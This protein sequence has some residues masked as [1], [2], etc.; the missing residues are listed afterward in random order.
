M[1]FEYAGETAALLTSMVWA[2]SSQFHA[3][4]TKLLG[5]SGVTL[6]RVPYNILLLGVVFLFLR[7]EN[8]FSLE[9][10]LYIAAAAF[11]GIAF[12]DTS[13][14]KAV[15]LIGPRLACLVQSMSSCFTAI[16]GYFILGESIGV[17]G[18]LGI[19][20]AIFGVFFVL[21]DGGNLT[22]TPTGQSSKKELAHGAALG[23]F[24]ALM[25]AGS[26]I[27][28]K[29]AL[30]L[31]VSP[32]GA[33][34]LRLIF[35]GL[36]LGSFFAYKGWLGKIWSTFR[37]TPAS[38]KFMLAGGF[39]TALGVWFSGEAVKYAEAGVAATIIALE[40]VM[41]IPVNAIYERRKP[42]A[43]AIIGTCIAFSGIAI[44]ILR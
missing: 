17:I 22:V 32:L 7:P 3:S 6:L 42:G 15:D 39:F 36:M 33:G 25:L 14:Y 44:L 41:I 27:C 8:D 13:F 10:T 43:R 9:S 1:S 20:V 28:T 16:L 4:A 35:G 40:P 19:G 21:A 38:W 34:I 26:L 2:L 30:I 11:F 29:Q 24:S 5:V 37:H 12:C 31:G 18:A 23:L